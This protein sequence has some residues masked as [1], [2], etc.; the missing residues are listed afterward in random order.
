MSST[1]SLFPL[2]ITTTTILELYNQCPYKLQTLVIE[3]WTK[4]IYN[5]HLLFG[6]EFASAL[7][8]TRKAYYYECLSATESIDLG[9]QQILNTFAV[10]FEPSGFNNDIKTPSRMQEVFTRYFEEYPLDNDITPYVLPAGDLSVECSFIVELPYLHPELGIPILLS[11][12]PDMLGID[13]RDILHLVDEKTASQSGMNDMVKSTSMYRSRIQFM[14]YTSVINQHPEHFGTAKVTQTKVRRVVMTKSKLMDKTGCIPKNSKVVEEYSFE[15]DKWLQ[16]EIWEETLLIVEEMLESYSKYKQ[17]VK[18]AFR[19]R[20]GN[21]E[22]FFNPC[23][24]TMYCTSGSAQDLERDGYIQMWRDKDKNEQRPMR[25]QRI[26]L[27]L[28]V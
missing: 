10:T 5:N 19:R 14:L 2:R 28:P 24:L 1:V 17:G 3:G 18:H 21:C 7:E 27:G 6:S 4:S 26:L 25:E 11:I 12:K 16:G 9:L 22:R 8:T 15:I 20:R 13:S 23:E